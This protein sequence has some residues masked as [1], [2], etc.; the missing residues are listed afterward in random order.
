[1]P[2]RVWWLV[3]SSVVA[4]AQTKVCFTFAVVAADSGTA[5]TQVTP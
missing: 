2:V 5:G 1:M 3:T 4:S